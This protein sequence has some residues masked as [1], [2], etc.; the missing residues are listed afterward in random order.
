MRL[1]NREKILLVVL[2]V[3]IA[4]LG[5]F[6]FVMTP[7]NETLEEMTITLEEE[8]L[9]YT[10]LKNRALEK[11]DLEDK[12]NE[13]THEIMEIASNFY[14]VL[15]QEDIIVIL[16]DLL[17]HN[18]FEI[19]T[20]NFSQPTIEEFGHHRDEENEDSE[21]TTDLIKLNQMVVQTNYTGNYNGIMDLLSLLEE[22]ENKVMLN[23]LSV[24]GSPDGWLTGTA[25][26]HFYNVPRVKRYYPSRPQTVTYTLLEDALKV[27]RK[28]PFDTSGMPTPSTKDSV[29]NDGE[30][31]GLEGVGVDTGSSDREL[32]DEELIQMIGGEEKSSSDHFKDQSKIKNES[33]SFYDHIKR[34]GIEKENEWVLTVVKGDTLYHIAMAFYGSKE[35]I[36][37]II[38]ANNIEDPSLIFIGDVLRIPKR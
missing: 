28:N 34:R 23:S 30:K 21:E 3:A 16:N 35:K 25:T 4:L 36:V 12:K 8:T 5:F 32:T 15:E 18:A 37:Y 14:G 19:N 26:Y 22:Y 24:T 38:E 13:T 29:I 17:V 7:I 10:R 31:T 20:M 2:T 1:N 11:P 6:R 33:L 27:E 9:E